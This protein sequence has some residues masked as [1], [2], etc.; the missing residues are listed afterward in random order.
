MKHENEKDL[1]HIRNEEKGKC[2]DKKIKECKEKGKV[3]NP[4]SEDVL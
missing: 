2:D 3:C 4:D 1:N